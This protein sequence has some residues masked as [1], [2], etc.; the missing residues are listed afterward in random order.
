MAD[1]IYGGN[2]SGGSVSSFTGDGTLLNNSASTGAVTA[3]LANAP[4]NTVWGNNTGSSAAPG[5]Q[6]SINISGTA[7]TAAHTITSNSANSLAVGA[8]GTTNPTLQID[9]SAAS[10]ATGWDDVA[11]AAGSGS[12]LKVISSGTN[13]SGDVEAKG[14]GALTL[15]GTATGA[16][17]IGNASSGATTI[18]GANGTTFAVSINAANR[19]TVNSTGF[20]FNPGAVGNSVHYPFTAPA[21]TSIT[22]SA[23]TPVLSVG[24]SSIVTRQWATGT[25][26]D[27]PVDLLYGIKDAFVG[28]ST[29]TM[30][31]TLEVQQSDCGTNGTC[32]TMAGIY[33]PTRAYTGTVGTGYGIYSVAPTAAGTANY[34]LGTSGNVNMSGLATASGSETSALCLDGSGNVI[35]DSVTCISS[36]A[37]FK[38]ITG[39]VTNALNKIMKLTPEKYKYKDSY[40]GNYRNSPNH[41]REQIGLIAENVAQV[42][43]DLVVW[44]K[45]GKTPHSVRYDH[46][47]ALLVAAMQEQEAKINSLPASVQS[48][49]IND[50]KQQILWLKIGVFISLILSLGAIYRT[51]KTTQM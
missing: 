5:Y 38:D 51:R 31:E 2:S 24:N 11:A 7:A 32:T 34:A 47:T 21:D 17:N 22:A 41:N 12:L 13:E 19:F 18:K 16:I 33:V 35:A 48:N 30:G 36:S 3:T 37:R 44:E 10:A 46:V 45:D 1:G 50:L 9:S 25:L 15:N 8:N 20:T 4:A 14:T 49:E 28:A 26:A 42:E 23:T 40:L 43:P 29:Q 6:T 27:N 39:N